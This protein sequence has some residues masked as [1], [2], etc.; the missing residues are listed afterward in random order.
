MEWLVG[1][2][3]KLLFLGFLIFMSELDGCFEE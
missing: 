2:F 3:M 1:S